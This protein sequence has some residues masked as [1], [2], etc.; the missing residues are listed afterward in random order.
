MNNVIDGDFMRD[1]YTKDDICNVRKN[2]Y[3]IKFTAT[4]K[5]RLLLETFI[6][7]NNWTKQEAKEKVNAILA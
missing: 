6:K 7:E 5:L 1:E 2:P 3:A 4:D